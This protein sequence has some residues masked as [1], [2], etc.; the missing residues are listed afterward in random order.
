M[1]AG[2]TAGQG[3]N[4]QEHSQVPGSNPYPAFCTPVNS[5]EENPQE[6]KLGGLPGCIWPQERGRKCLNRKKPPRHMGMEASGCTVT[7][8][9]PLSNAN[10][11]PR[12]RLAHLGAAQGESLPAMREQHLQT[13]TES[14]PAV[15]PADGSRTLTMPTDHTGTHTVWRCRPSV[16]GH[17]SEGTERLAAA[18]PPWE[19]GFC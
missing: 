2:Q 12:L 19:G 3:A 16:A 17:S 15:E 7:C 6:A 14:S 11:R 9:P 1:D 8:P 18:S 4:L 10:F 13:G 5:G